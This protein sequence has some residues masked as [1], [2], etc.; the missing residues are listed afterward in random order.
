[1]ETVVKLSTVD[2]IYAGEH[3][4][5]IEDINL[6]VE[7]GEFISVVGPNGSGKTTLLETINGLLKVSKG[8]V[9]VFDQDMKC[10]P[11][12][13]RKDI[14][15]VPQDFIS[16]PSVPF[17]AKD[18]VLM[19]RYGKIG[20]LRAPGRIDREIA[21][22][23]MRLV[24]VDE[25]ADRPIGKLSGGE[26]QKIMIARAIAQ[27]PKLLLLDEPFSN[28]DVD[29]KREISERI[30]KLH[31]EKGLTTIVVTHD[32]LSIPKRCYRV[33]VMDRGRIVAEGDPA[34]VIRKTEKMGVFFE[35][36]KP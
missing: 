7:R 1:M 24:G 14:G 2:S 32:I 13:V 5:A 26:Q 30:C 33:V 9:M 6:E 29:S 20:L 34:S 25:F 11:M 8:K 19:S 35:G 36:W 22:D 18:V 10:H 15:Y 23:T 27:E 16:A 12:K 28:L 3:L 31:E 21:M 4:P 17:L